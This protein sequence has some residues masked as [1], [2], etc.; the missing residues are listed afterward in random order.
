LLAAADFGVVGE[1]VETGFAEHGAGDEA[2]GEGLGEFVLELF[3]VAEDGADRESGREDSGRG[4]AD[5]LLNKAIFLGD[6]EVA[7]GGIEGALLLAAVFGEAF[8]ALLEVGVFGGLEEIVEGTVFGG[9]G[10]VEAPG[11]IEKS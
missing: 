8:V 3:E 11:G 1:L 6:A 9:L 5:V 2:E 4:E 7:E 10:L